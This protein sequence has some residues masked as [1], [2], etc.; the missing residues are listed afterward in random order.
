MW[1]WLRACFPV[2]YTYPQVDLM[3][4]SSLKIFIFVYTSKYPFWSIFLYVTKIKVEKQCYH[5]SFQTKPT[6]LL[7][8]GEQIKCNVVKSF[9]V[10][11]TGCLSVRRAATNCNDSNCFWLRGRAFHS[12]TFHFILIPLRPMLYFVIVDTTVIRFFFTSYAPFHLRRKYLIRGQ[13]ENILYS[14]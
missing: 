11:K 8:G 7:I 6:T 4:L 10:S 3:L 5:F 14:I 9:G 12:I 1:V 2:F 13:V